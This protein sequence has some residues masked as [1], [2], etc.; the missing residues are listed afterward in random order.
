MLR[1]AWVLIALLAGCV[2]QPNDSAWPPGPLKVSFSAALDVEAFE[3]RRALCKAGPP[4]AFAADLNGREIDIPL[5]RF[6]RA[7]TITIDRDASPRKYDQNPDGPDGCPGIP[8]FS[9]RLDVRLS[10]DAQRIRP[11]VY[12]PVLTLFGFDLSDTALVASR[13]FARNRLAEGRCHEASQ[14]TTLCHVTLNDLERPLGWMSPG[15]LL[16]AHRIPAFENG[17]PFFIFCGEKEGFCVIRERLADGVSYWLTYT[18]T[19]TSHREAANLWVR[20]KP[21]AQYYL[22]GGGMAPPSITAR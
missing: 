13:R 14:N 17:D 6:A 9:N 5:D 11:G 2:T 21:L 19:V 7:I 10:P 4:R 16:F 22:A 12:S 18:P 15:T 3:K 20:L 8:F 1:V